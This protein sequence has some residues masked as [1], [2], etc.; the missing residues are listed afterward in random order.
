MTIYY[1]D[2][3]GI[4]GETLSDGES[5]ESIDF[6]DGYAYFTAEQ[7]SGGLID[8]KIPLTALLRIER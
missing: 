8:K 7:N 6:A 1:R 5:G 2:E 3:I 4:V